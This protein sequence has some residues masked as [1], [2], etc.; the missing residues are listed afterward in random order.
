MPICS[1]YGYTMQVWARLKRELGDV[2]PV[3]H[4]GCRGLRWWSVVGGLSSVVRL[5][6]SQ[7]PAESWVG[8]GMVLTR[9]STSRL[10]TFVGGN[11]TS[12][13]GPL[14]AFQYAFKFYVMLSQFLVFKNVH[15]CGRK[16]F[17][18]V[19]FKQGLLCI[20]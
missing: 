5:L 18:F 6:P 13:A 11:F 2:I 20:W 14:S 4:R 9:T 16:C 10:Q 15:S 1:S 3:S 19:V 17:L 12:R 8:G 7:A